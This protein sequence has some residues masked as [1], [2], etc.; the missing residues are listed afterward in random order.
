VTAVVQ[1]LSRHGRDA[2]AGV[3]RLRFQ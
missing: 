2:R 3:D 1:R